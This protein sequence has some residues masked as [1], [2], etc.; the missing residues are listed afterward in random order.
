MMKLRKVDN[1]LASDLVTALFR[2]GFRAHALEESEYRNIPEFNWDL[3]SYESAAAVSLD[4]EALDILHIVTVKEKGQIHYRAKI[5]LP[6]PSS[7][8]NGLSEE[9]PF[10]VSFRAD[11]GERWK[12]D[13]GGRLEQ[14]VSEALNRAEDLTSSLLSSGHMNVNAWLDV[15]GR[16]SINTAKRYT[17]LEGIT[18]FIDASNK[19]VGC[20]QSVRS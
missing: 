5:L 12:D 15:D 9:E 20:I 8:L 16:L 13:M 4:A 18:D 17:T 2:E 1:Q 3:R 10:S 11:I 14:N 19:I 6:C 7:I